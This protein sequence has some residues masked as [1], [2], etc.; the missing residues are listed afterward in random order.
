MQN[1]RVEIL[2]DVVLLCFANSITFEAKE[3][4]Q[5]INYD[6]SCGVSTLDRQVGER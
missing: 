3:N 5:K 4:K 6:S 2:V 1:T